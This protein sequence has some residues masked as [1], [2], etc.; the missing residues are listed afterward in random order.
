MPRMLILADDL[1]GAADCGVACAA[2]G[3]ETVVALNRLARSA[4]AEVLSV[5]ADTRRMTPEEACREVDRLIRQCALDPDLLFFQKIDST[6]RGNVA[7]E[8]AAALRTY[9]SLHQVAGETVAVM[10]PAFPANGRTTV[11]GVQLVRGQ[12]LHD[13]ELWRI[14]GMHGRAYIPDLLQQ[15]GLES[16]LLHLDAV[17]AGEPVLLEKMTAAARQ[18]AVVVCDAET[19]ADLAAIARASMELRQRVIW[20]GSAGLAYHLP[21][22][23]GLPR[24]SR[25]AER[26]L[27]SLSGPLL[28]VIGSISRRS[29]EQVQLLIRSS[30]TVHI[31]APAEVL[32]AGEQ[33]R[34][35]RQLV[36]EL[37]GAV[38]R[39]QDLV[40]ECAPEPVVGAAQR[41][42]L[43]AALA[44][45]TTA[46]RG[47]IG[48]LI[49]S[50]G[51]TARMVFDAWGVTRM[52]LMGEIEK[53]IPIATAEDWSRPLPIMTK[54]GDFGSYEA[55]LKCQQYLRRTSHL[56][57]TSQI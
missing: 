1:T 52:R 15:S 9:G 34:G 29:V 55:L 36:G 37:E 28:F 30:R 41:P 33:T 8:L 18:A 46:V 47:K 11:N 43:S 21:K 17:R 57:R 2:A 48:A 40:L 6:L 38:E 24:T 7:A 31:T 10:A 14:G 50:G 49:A 35:W 4:D 45:I 20:A 42:M 25:S 44:Q 53:G 51:E 26:V 3:L 23:A 54:A 56:H 13:T 12:P 27:S 32:L 5:D 16:A 22:A 39:N 19:E